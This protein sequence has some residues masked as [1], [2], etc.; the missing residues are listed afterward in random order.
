MSRNRKLS[1]WWLGPYRVQK[2]IPAKGTY[3]LEEFD[4]TPLAG[5][6]AGNR[7]KKFVEQER[8]YIPAEGYKNQD[9]ESENEEPEQ[10]TDPS[11]E[12]IFLERSTRPRRVPARYRDD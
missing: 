8:F 11:D 1:Y 4:G 2:A 6:Y 5:T 3:I 12:E 9:S 10:D 7:L